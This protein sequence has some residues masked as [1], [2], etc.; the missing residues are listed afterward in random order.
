MRDLPFVH[1]DLEVE[2]VGFAPWQDH[3]LGILI[4]PWF[5]NL[6]MLPCGDEFDELRQG[7]EVEFRFPSG[8]CDFTVTKDDVLGTFL[9]A[10][11]FRTVVDFPGQAF[12]R[13]V[14]LQAL[15]NLLAL[16]PV[17][18]PKIGRREFLRGPRTS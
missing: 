8:S 7:E 12:A 6:V 16:P 3:E 2:A 9:S 13:E 4:T 15:A 17:D 1:P 10:V 18:G 11:L 14:A 5:M